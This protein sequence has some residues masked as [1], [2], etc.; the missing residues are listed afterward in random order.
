MLEM[1]KTFEN[2]AYDL[3]SVWVAIIEQVYA[4]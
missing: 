3:E 2:A 1:Y 4:Q